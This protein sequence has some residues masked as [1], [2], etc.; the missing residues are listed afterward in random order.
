[1]RR[2]NFTS[3]LLIIGFLTAGWSAKAAETSSPI[4]GTW[5][6]VTSSMLTLDTNET[7]HPYGEHLKGYIQYS[8]GGHMVVFLAAEN[9]K[10]PA[11]AVYTDAERVE[12]HKAILGAYSGT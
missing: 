9:I 8:P 5:Q 4:V 1:M 2:S 3:M 10:Q 6:V 7:S 12:I 11:S